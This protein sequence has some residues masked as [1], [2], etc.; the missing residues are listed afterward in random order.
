MDAK[1]SVQG[2]SKVYDELLLEWN[3]VNNPN[4]VE[5]VKRETKAEMKEM[6]MRVKVEMKR[7]AMEVAAAAEFDI[8]KKG[9]I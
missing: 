2:G 4:W 8:T 6:R 5:P 9:A 7:L 3:W 1:R